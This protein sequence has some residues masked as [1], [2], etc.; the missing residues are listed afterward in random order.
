MP[1][2]VATSNAYNYVSPM[3]AVIS[4]NYNP[5]NVLVPQNVDGN[6]Y[7]WQRNTSYPTITQGASAIHY[8]KFIN[9]PLTGTGTIANVRQSSPTRNI[10]VPVSPTSKF[11]LLFASGSPLP[12]RIYFFY[13]NQAHRLKS[14]IT[15]MYILQLH[16][17]H[18]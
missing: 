3:Q 16:M 2:T 8:S 14:Q 13:K 11:E 17:H 10:S 4:P 12:S 1:T 18:Y 15:A 6:C 5:E 9:T 7:G